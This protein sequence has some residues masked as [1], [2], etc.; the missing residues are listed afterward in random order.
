MWGRRIAQWRPPYLLNNGF[1][2]NGLSHHRSPSSVKFHDMLGAYASRVLRYFAWSPLLRMSRRGRAQPPEAATQSH[3][4]LLR[5]LLH[6]FG[7][8]GSPFSG[9]RL[10][11]LLSA[12]VCLSVYKWEEDSVPDQHIARYIEDLGYVSRLTAETLTCKSC[13]QRLRVDT[14]VPGIDY[15]GCPDGKAPSPSGELDG[16]KPFIERPNT[17][18]WRKE[19]GDY[20]GL[21]AYKSNKS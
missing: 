5:V 1:P 8:R 14:K 3:R 9:S 21:Y 4:G 18:V 19:H 12:T 17:L 2:I 6:D 16:W 15:C 10:D 11:M 20:K 13:Q 7:R